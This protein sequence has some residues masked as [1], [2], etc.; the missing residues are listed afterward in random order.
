MHTIRFWVWH[1]GGPVK[2]AL[3]QGQ[4]VYCWRSGPTEEGFASH[5][6]RWTRVDH[7]TIKEDAYH[8]GS[9]CDGPYEFGGTSWA[10]GA[11][12]T[13]G[14]VD[15]N[16]PAIVYPTWEAGIHYQRDRYAEAMGY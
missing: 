7:N 12:I 15:T 6:T 8:E 16:D 5:S 9:D 11:A 14:D 10:S 13:G 1:R 4:T 3:R 2:L